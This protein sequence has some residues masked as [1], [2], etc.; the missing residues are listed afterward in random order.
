MYAACVLHANSLD[1]IIGLL[2]RKKKARLWV[3][4][5]RSLMLHVPFSLTIL[6]FPLDES[7]VPGFCTAMHKVAFFYT[8]ADRI[9]LGDGGYSYINNLHYHHHTTRAASQGANPS[10]IQQTPFNA[11]VHHWEL[12]WQDQ[13]PMES[14]QTLPLDRLSV[15]KTAK[16]CRVLHNICLWVRD[17]MDQALFEPPDGGKKIFASG[18]MLL[19]YI[20]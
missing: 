19:L 13:G 12:Y 6:Q 9:L 5:Y 18:V 2:A 1:C 16:T 11:K 17:I 7:T 15:P 14:R 10:S 8:P 3:K 4:Y 20:L